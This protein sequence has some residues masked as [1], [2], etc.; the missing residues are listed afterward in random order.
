MP[1]VETSAIRSLD[2]TDASF[3]NYLICLGFAAIKR[4]KCRVSL[5]AHCDPLIIFTL[6]PSPHC[7]FCRVWPCVDHENP[8]IRNASVTCLTNPANR[9]TQLVI[10]FLRDRIWCLQWF[11]GWDSSPTL[12]AAI[13]AFCKYFCELQAS[14]VKIWQLQRRAARRVAS[15]SVSGSTPGAGVSHQ[16]EAEKVLVQSPTQPQQ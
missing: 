8:I 7:I 13:I 14:V 10:D 5:G 12:T 11:S 6:E 2:G 15:N 1:A 3:K 16:A 9:L 4:R